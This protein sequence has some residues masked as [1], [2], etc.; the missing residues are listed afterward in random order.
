MKLKQPNDQ[1]KTAWNKAKSAREKEERE[2]ERGK[3]ENRVSFN[4]PMTRGLCKTHYATRPH[5][6]ALALAY[7]DQT[8]T[9]IWA[10]RSVQDR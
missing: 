2:R 7:S 5:T 10:P 8:H 9:M 3:E 1:N 6:L 4:K